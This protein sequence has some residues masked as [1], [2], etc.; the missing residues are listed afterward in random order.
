MSTAPIGDNTYRARLLAAQDAR[1]TFALAALRAPDLR[2]DVWRR[3]FAS[4]SARWPKEALVGVYNAAGCI[5]MVLQWNQGGFDML[6]SAPPI[7]YDNDSA[8][9]AATV[10]IDGLMRSVPATD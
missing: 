2:F 8:L 4:K 1:A 7:L 5:I 10:A 3:K 9:R 6:A